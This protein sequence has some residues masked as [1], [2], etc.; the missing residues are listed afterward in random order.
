MDT[1]SKAPV[2][3]QW[4]VPKM[5]IHDSS[6]ATSHTGS[7]TVEVYYQPDAV[8]IVP[9]VS[10]TTGDAVKLIAYDPRNKVKSHSHTAPECEHVRGQGS[11]GMRIA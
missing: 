7:I 8:R 11:L 2:P 9:R 4:C 5:H 6:Q 10:L 3:K 1:H